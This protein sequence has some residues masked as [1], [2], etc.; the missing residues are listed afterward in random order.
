ME[1]QNILSNTQ[2][3]VSIAG[4]FITKAKQQDSKGVHVTLW[5]N[6]T[7][8]FLLYVNYGSCFSLWLDVTTQTRRHA[9]THTHT[10]NTGVTQQG[11]F[12]LHSCHSSFRN[13]N[14]LRTA[15]TT[16]QSITWRILMFWNILHSATTIM[17]FTLHNIFKLCNSKPQLIVNRVTWCHK[18]RGPTHSMAFPSFLRT[19]LQ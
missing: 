11:V 3:K 13:Q 17:S 15:K 6:K 7:L 9:Y 18:A 16:A 5:Q 1:Y 14:E 4:C 8:V 10:L 19:L 12:P 2:V